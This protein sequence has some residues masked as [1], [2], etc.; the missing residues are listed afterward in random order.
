MT[1]DSV[2]LSRLHEKAR[3]WLIVLKKKRHVKKENMVT[4]LTQVTV[5][6]KLSLVVSAIVLQVPRQLEHEELHLHRFLC[7][8]IFDDS[9]QQMTKTQKGNAT[10]KG[11]T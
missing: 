1:A 11:L 8:E 3:R 10:T 9:L 7:C 4:Y 6:V 5:R 2:V